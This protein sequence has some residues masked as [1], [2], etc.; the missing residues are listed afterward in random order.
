MTTNILQKINEVEDEWQEN[1]HKT[2]T[3]FTAKVQVRGDNV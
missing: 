1:S 3:K 2:N